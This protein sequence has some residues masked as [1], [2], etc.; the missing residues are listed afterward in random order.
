MKVA[1]MMIA[2]EKTE[3][4]TNAQETIAI[5][6]ENWMNSDK[7]AILPLSTEFSDTN[8]YIGLEYLGLYPYISGSKHDFTNFG[9]LYVHDKATNDPYFFQRWLRSEIK[10]GI[11]GQ[12]LP[13]KKELK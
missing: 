3:I 6:T 1:G 11:T 13:Y 4:E 9:L 12:P 5:S 8:E 7:V 2:T 10:I